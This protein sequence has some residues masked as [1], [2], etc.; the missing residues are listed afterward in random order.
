MLLWST[1]FVL[2]RLPV[3]PLPHDH[4]SAVLHGLLVEYAVHLPKTRA[5]RSMPC[6]LATMAFARATAPEPPLARSSKSAM[7]AVRAGL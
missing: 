5:N 2:D 4:H 3:K 7:I 1:Q 6:S